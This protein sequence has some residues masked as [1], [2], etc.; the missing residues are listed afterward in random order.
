MAASGNPPG[1]PACPSLMSPRFWGL[2]PLPAEPLARSR[3]E[4]NSGLRSAAR[5]WPR[6]GCCCSTSRW[7]GWTPLCG[8]GC[9]PIWGACAMNFPFRCC[10]SPTRPTKSWRCATMDRIGLAHP[11]HRCFK[12]LL[13]AQAR[14]RLPLHFLPQMAFQLLQRHWR[15]NSGGQHLPAPLHDCFLQVKHF[16]LSRFRPAPRK[17][18]STAHIFPGELVCRPA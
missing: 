5:C 10:M 14:L 6:P 1:Q 4:K 3:A 2:P 13:R 16:G 12:S 7:L 8:I 9:N 11:H 18:W 15:T 17:S